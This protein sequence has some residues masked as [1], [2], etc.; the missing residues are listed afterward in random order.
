MAPSGNTDTQT[1]DDTQFNR[2][3]DPFY[4]EKILVENKH[5]SEI[6]TKTTWINERQEPEFIRDVCPY[7]MP[8]LCNAGVFATTIVTG[9]PILGAWIMFVGTPIY[10]WFLYHDDQ[11]IERRNEK[12][13]MKS[14]MFLIPLYTYIF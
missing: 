7:F 12:M 3:K 6:N 4:G 5:I 11:N 13:W 8:T 1:Q 2:E 10:N 9:R 14:S